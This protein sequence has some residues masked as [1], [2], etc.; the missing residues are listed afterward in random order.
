MKESKF[1][2]CL[3]CGGKISSQGDGTH[4]WNIVYE[5]GKEIAGAIGSDEYIVIGKCKNTSSDKKIGLDSDVDKFN[6]IG[7]QIDY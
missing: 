5:C 7:L 6:S 2:R 4:A 1:N 3:D